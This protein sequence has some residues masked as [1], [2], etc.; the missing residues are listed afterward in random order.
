MLETKGFP[1][2][3]ET[4]VVEYTVP[5][6][7]HRYTVDFPLNTVLIES[8]GYFPS[9]DRTKMK[10]IKASRPDLDL[11]LV[12]MKADT[13]ITKGSKT[14]YAK[15]AEKNGFPWAEKEIPESWI[16]EA[17]SKKSEGT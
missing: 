13:P 8:K 12:F 3:Y 1:D 7:V 14:T 17:H 10:N 5:A 6:K 9:E 2:V 11:R 15:W 4:V 16:I